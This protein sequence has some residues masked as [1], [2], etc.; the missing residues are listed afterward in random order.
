MNKYNWQE[1][2]NTTIPIKLRGFFLSI[3]MIL[4]TFEGT[5]SNL[6][7]FDLDCAVTAWRRKGVQLSPSRELVKNVL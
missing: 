3:L 1:I 5:N 7:S 6:M 2:R 4:F